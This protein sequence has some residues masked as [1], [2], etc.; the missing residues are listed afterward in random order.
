MHNLISEL[1]CTY[2]DC[3]MLPTI[4][5]GINVLDFG[6]NQ[7][8]VKPCHSPIYAKT[9]DMAEGLEDEEKDEG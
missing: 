9:F 1:L 2:G 8:T 6:R 7:G 3:H 5:K 4:S